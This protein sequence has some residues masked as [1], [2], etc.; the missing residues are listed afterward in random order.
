M[1]P[2]PDLTIAIEMGKWL[3]LGA[4]ATLAYRFGG[5]MDRLSSSIEHL[6]SKLEDHDDRLLVLEGRRR[7]E[8]LHALDGQ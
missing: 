2:L 6:T 4:A 3:L 5:K 8:R 7:D 1:H